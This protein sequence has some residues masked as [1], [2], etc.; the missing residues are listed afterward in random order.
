MLP[1]IFRDEVIIDNVRI[2]IKDDGTEVHADTWDKLFKSPPK[3]KMDLKTK[4]NNPNKQKLWMKNI[5]GY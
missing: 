1:T 4:G 3:G 2:Y 5:K